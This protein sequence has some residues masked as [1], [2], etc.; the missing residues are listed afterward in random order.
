MDKFIEV[1]I[2][3]NTPKI[4]SLHITPLH[5]TDFDQDHEDNYS[6]WKV[7]IYMLII[8]YN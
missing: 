8:E 5:G 6:K 2:G 7:S 1:W 3:Y 4:T